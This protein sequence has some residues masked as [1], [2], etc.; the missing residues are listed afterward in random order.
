MRDAVFQRNFKTWHYF[1]IK[2]L[3]CF[4]PPLPPHPP[5]SP[6]GQHSSDPNYQ[7]HD[8]TYLQ[9]KPCDWHI[10]CLV[11]RERLWL[12]LWPWRGVDISVKLPSPLQR[13]THHGSSRC[14]TS[15]LIFIPPD[16]HQEISWSQF[17]PT[18][19]MWHR[20]FGSL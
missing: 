3:H 19:C 13:P 6:E 14:E 8:R 5:L 2:R 20:Y 18:S 12:W 11:T 9:I 4:P 1:T 17:W 15:L 10:P 7:S 16:H